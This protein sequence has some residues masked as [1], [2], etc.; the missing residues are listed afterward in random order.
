MGVVRF[1]AKRVAALIVTMALVIS[2]GFIFMEISP[3]SYF[4]A[5][6]LASQMGVLSISHPQLYQQYIHMFETR[7]GLNQPL[8]KEA[9]TYVWHS[10][11][12]NF[13]NSFENPSVSIMSQLKTA[14]PISLMLAGG[15]IVF[16]LVIGVPLGVIAALKRNT[17]IDSFVISLSMVGQA[18]PSYVIAVLL[19]LL[20]GVVI[21]DV[22]PINGWGQPAD[23]I[24]PIVALSAGNI[25]VV[26]RYMRTS[27]VDTFRQPYVRTAEAKGVKYWPLV[28]KHVMRNSLTALIT[29][30]GPTFAITVVNTVW[31]ENIFSI[32]GMGVLMSGAFVS[33]DIPLS[34][35][36][37]FI[38]C[39]FVMGVNILVDFL[40]ALIDPRVR[41]E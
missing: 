1:F 24:L 27:M 26:T 19:V 18:I 33:K 5:A 10:L 31:V 9:L 7:Y 12:F 2:V 39:L 40:Y 23:A 20:F 3:G 34:V 21:P 36:N 4:S 17:W 32:P 37:V 8:W 11:T 15:S 30:I 41:L 29:V 38:L 25:A 16:A 13:G 6:T 22:V 28:F 35:T 14:F